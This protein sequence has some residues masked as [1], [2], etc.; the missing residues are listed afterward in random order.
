MAFGFYEDMQATAIS[1]IREFGT[2]ITFK[3]RL[4]AIDFENSYPVEYAEYK[5]FGIL[6]N[7]TDQEKAAQPAQENHDGIINGDMKVLSA[8]NADYKPE[9]GDLVVFDNIHYI[10]INSERIAPAGIPVIDKLQV[11]SYGQI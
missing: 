7:Y 10:I 6:L 8:F 2:I 5:G 4:P 11:R 1:L 9:V 3:Q